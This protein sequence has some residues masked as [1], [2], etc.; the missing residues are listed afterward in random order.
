MNV[1]NAEIV[2]TEFGNIRPLASLQPAQ[3]DVIVNATGVGMHKSEG[4]SPVGA[5]FLSR[6]NLACDLIYCPKRAS[7]CALRKGSAKRS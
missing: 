4:V 3:Y 2:A 6:C 7:F 1:Q 5:E